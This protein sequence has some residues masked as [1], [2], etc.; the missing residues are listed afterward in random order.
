MSQS[1]QVLSAL[2]SGDLV[3]ARAAECFEGV[4]SFGCATAFGPILIADALML[5]AWSRVELLPPF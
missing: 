3:Y 5:P 2:R 4:C 1:A